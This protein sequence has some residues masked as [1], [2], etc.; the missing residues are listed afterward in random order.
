MHGKYDNGLGRRA[1]GRVPERRH[2]RA[3]DTRCFAGCKVTLRSPL[4][5]RGP[6]AALRRTDR[7]LV[8]RG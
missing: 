5:C 1:P 7:L 6:A 2:D 3:G 8:P 4:P